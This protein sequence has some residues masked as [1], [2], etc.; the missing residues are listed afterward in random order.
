MPGRDRRRR[1][2]GRAAGRVA[3]VARVAG[4]GGVE[5]GEGRR[6]GLAD[7]RRAGPLQR[8]RRAARRP[9][10]ASRHRSA[11]HLGRQVGGVDDVLDADRDAAQRPVRAGWSP[12]G[13]PSRRRR[14][15]RRR[16]SDRVARQP[17]AR[18]RAS[19][20]RPRCGA[21]DRGWTAWSGAPS[22]MTGLVPRR[23]A[24]ASR[25][26]SAS[27]GSVDGAFTNSVAS[28]APCA[29]GSCVRCPDARRT[30]AYRMRAVPFEQREP[31][32]AQAEEA[33]LPPAGAALGLH[34]ARVARSTAPAPAAWTIRSRSRPSRAAASA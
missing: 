20:C 29:V 14:C 9:S 33:C 23:L 1:P 31:W 12:R 27:G 7:H 13:P 18:R 30:G 6:R 16:C 34:V 11:S 24:A 8:R 25:P 5:I 17:D 2:G 32:R 4:R 10:A 28:S 15:R 22:R 26:A 3:G 19:G 21:E